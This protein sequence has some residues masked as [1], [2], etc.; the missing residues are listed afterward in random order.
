MTRPVCALLALIAGGVW[1]TD[2]RSLQD[3]TDADW[4][5]V[6]SV[7]DQVLDSLMPLELK[8]RQVV[9]YRSSSDSMRIGVIERHLTVSYAERTTANPDAFSASVVT[10][11]GPSI[12]RQLLDL[13]MA[14]RSMPFDVIL[15]RIAVRRFVVDGGG[16]PA[17]RQRMRALANV[18]IPLPFG[19][20]ETVRIFIHPI[21]HRLVVRTDALMLDATD[22]DSESPLVRWAVRTNDDLIACGR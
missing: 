6:D 11:V 22:F 18:S 10:P 7:Q 3:P 8:P 17:L 9:A 15:A 16:C 20:G 1:S 14:N 21:A 19:D 5:W 13:R 12:L 2:A 4:R